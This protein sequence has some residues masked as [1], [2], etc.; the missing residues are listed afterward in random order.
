MIR[1]YF[2][3][4]RKLQEAN[5]YYYGFVYL[6]F[7]CFVK[8]QKPYSV[9]LKYTRWEEDYISNSDDSEIKLHGIRK[10]AVIY[11]D[12]FLEYVYVIFLTYS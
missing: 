3:F 12:K 11:W 1:E 10:N 5:E 4:W 8:S 7:M 6:L 2:I 9:S